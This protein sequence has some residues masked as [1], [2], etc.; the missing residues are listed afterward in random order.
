MNRLMSLIFA[1]SVSIVPVAFAQQQP[2]D[3]DAIVMPNPPA[4]PAIPGLTWDGELAASAAAFAAECTFGHSGDQGVGENTY[5]GSS[6]TLVS[7]N[8][9]VKAWV[10]EQQYYDASAC[11]CQEGQVCGHYTQVIW[12]NTTFVG[13]G[14][15]ICNT[16]IDGTWGQKWV[17]QYKTPGNVVGQCPYK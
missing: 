8:A 15:A 2:V 5:Y 7:P 9:V 14:A 4:L 6:T 16:K 12:A 17:C 13:C 10:S 1:M 3:A 11:T